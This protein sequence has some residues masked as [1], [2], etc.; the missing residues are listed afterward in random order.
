MEYLLVVI[1]VAISR[2][3]VSQQMLTPALVRDCFN[4]MEL[5]F[6]VLDTLQSLPHVQLY[7]LISIIRLHCR[8]HGK[9]S[10]TDSSSSKKTDRKRRRDAAF[11]IKDVVNEIDRIMGLIRRKV[12]FIVHLTPEISSHQ[13]PDF[14][15]S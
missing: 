9:D 1:R 4:Q 6:S 7:I 14:V 15:T 8:T 2:L 3:S 10:G 11:T 13:F 5:P 12:G